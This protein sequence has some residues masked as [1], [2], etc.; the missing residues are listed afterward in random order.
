MYVPNINFGLLKSTLQVDKPQFQN[1]QRCTTHFC[2]YLLLRVGRF[3]V[4]LYVGRT[5]DAAEG[6]FMMKGSFKRACGHRSLK[7]KKS[8]EEPLKGWLFGPCAGQVVFFVL[9]SSIDGGNG[10]TEV[11]RDA[12]WPGRKCPVKRNKD[13]ETPT[14]IEGIQRLCMPGFAYPNYL[15]AGW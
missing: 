5:Y 2:F 13:L 6:R 3:F 8:K 12:T 11:E 10:A 7:A 9:H 15:F 4:W 1:I 14:E